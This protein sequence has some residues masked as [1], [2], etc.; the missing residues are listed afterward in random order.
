MSSQYS[1][2]VSSKVPGAKQEIIQLEI[3]KAKLEDPQM[4][5]LFISLP[6]VASGAWCTHLGQVGLSG[7]SQSHYKCIN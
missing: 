5:C 2:K 1:V 7:S 6:N 3:I 4:L